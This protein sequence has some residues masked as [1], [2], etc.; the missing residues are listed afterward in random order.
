MS[1]FYKQVEVEVDISD[2]SE[3]ELIEAVENL[4][5]LVIEKDYTEG[6]SESLKDDIYELYRDFIEGK[7]LNSKLKKFF[8]DQLDILVA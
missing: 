8:E 5:F 4:G 1:T 2:F 3:D 6:A 7:D